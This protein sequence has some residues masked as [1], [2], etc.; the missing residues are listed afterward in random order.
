[1]LRHHAFGIFECQKV[2]GDVIKT[3]TPSGQPLEIP[4][5]LVGEQHVREDCGGRIPS[6]QD[7]VMNLNMERW[8]NHS[9][10][11]SEIND[12]GHWSYKKEK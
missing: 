7:W 9:Y 10:P 1:M 2:F 11:E 5:R 12:P 6:V 3:T 4:T 8:M